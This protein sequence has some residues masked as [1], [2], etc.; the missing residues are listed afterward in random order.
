MRL[1]EKDPG[2]NWDLLD[3]VNFFR[4]F[5]CPSHSPAGTLASSQEASQAT[6]DFVPGVYSEML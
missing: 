5:S 6:I 3:L 1:L 2:M 4:R